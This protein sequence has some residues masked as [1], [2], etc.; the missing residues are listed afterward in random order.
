LAII[1]N[2]VVKIGADIS[3][4]QKSLEDAQTSL[5]RTGTKLS[6][7]GG[8]LSTSLT[9]PLAAAGAIVTKTGMDFEAA[10]SEVG[11][12]S[13]ATG[14][15]LKAL[16]AKAKEMGA[17]TKFS[18]SQSAEALKYMAMAGWDTS[19][20]LDGLEGV[21]SLAAASGEELGT[22]SDIVTD[23]MTAFGMEASR[24]GE[25]ADILAAASSKANTNV[26][27]LGESFKYV[28][29]VTGALGYSAQDTAVALSLMANAGIK[30]SQS[31]TAMRSILTRLVK[32][33]K[34]SGSSM[35]ALGISVMDSEGKMKT[36]AQIMDDLRASFA[37]LSPE[38]KAFHAAQIAG[39]EAMSGLLAIVN[40]SEADYDKLS[41]AINNAGGAANKMAAEMQDNLAGRLELLKSA[42]EGVA[43]Q[44]YDAMKPALEA[45][46]SVI[47]KLVD[48][49]GSLSPGIQKAIVVFAGLAAAIGPV[50]LLIGT[51]ATGLS[52]GIGTLSLLITPI[53]LIVAAIAGLGAALI[54]LWKTNEAFKNTVI[55]AWQA[56]KETLES[57]FNSII[58]AASTV[59]AE[60]GDSLQLLFNK[61][62]PL[63]EDLKQLFMSLVEV[64]TQLWQLLQPIFFALGTVV[65]GLL[66][67]ATGVINGIIQ[68]L[69]PLLDGVVNAVNIIID[70][71]GLVIALL[72]GDWAAAWDFMKSIAENTWE[73]VKN[74]F[75]AI[76]NFVKGFVEGII[77]FFKGL[78]YALVGGSII[79]DIVNRALKWFQKLLT[80]VN[81]TVGLLIGS[82][83]NAFNS[84]AGII[85]NVVGSAWQWGANLTNS[86]AKGIRSGL[87]VVGSAVRSVASKIK[88]FLGFSSPTK[89]GPGRESDKWMPNMIAMLESGIRK[90]LPDIRSAALDLAGSLSAIGNTSTLKAAV[91]P[92]DA[93]NQNSSLQIEN[94]LSVNKMEMA[95]DL[96]VYKLSQK[97]AEVLKEQM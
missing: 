34:E 27:M 40:A 49:F 18:A 80:G 81:Q 17:S 70:A 38:Q 64:I 65:A 41:N 88:G 12:I 58:T 92:G 24:A 21:M 95:G 28:A 79:P 19:K 68:A 50:L 61:V 8:K 3:T 35:A 13:G 74:I 94:L 37:N 16:E 51:M 43:I 56:I 60:F 22:V 14:E 67:I 71:I 54:Y 93:V 10:M 5:K 62:K 25:F 78:W 45:V 91:A 66:A 36:F 69:G 47:Q 89:E 11:A 73:L 6:N 87:S 83:K 39:Q 55:K 23:A 31:G 77:A 32:P 9:L 33:T 29:P 97:I 7:L 86:L 96:D 15:D 84:I 1:R 30:A 53:G 44:L 46:L 90:G 75:T 20:M 57:I 4:L 26:G 52:A 2:I 82:V 72:N 63:W 42:L 59:F 85:Q 48:W 76:V